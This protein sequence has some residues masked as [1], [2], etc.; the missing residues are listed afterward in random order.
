MGRAYSAGV[1]E[2]AVEV[3]R[4]PTRQARLAFIAGMAVASAILLGLFVGWPA[5]VIVIVVVNIVVAT[6]FEVRR[7]R[8]TPMWRGA[9]TI[10]GLAVVGSLVTIGVGVLAVLAVV[11]LAFLTGAV[12]IGP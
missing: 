8:D 3:D 4:S 1:T 10:A 12:R 5:V 7:T 6:R 11:Y 2:R 9:L